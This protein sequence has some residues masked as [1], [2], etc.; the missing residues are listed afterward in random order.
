MTFLK[1]VL[2]RPLV[3]SRSKAAQLNGNHYLLDT[4]LYEDGHPMECNIVSKQLT[5]Q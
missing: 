4:R 3:R 5:T 1:E 2:N